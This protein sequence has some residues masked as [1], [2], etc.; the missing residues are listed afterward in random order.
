LR[1]SAAT[2]ALTKMINQIKAERGRLKTLAADS[3]LMVQGEGMEL[4]YVGIYENGILYHR[5]VVIG[6]V[7]TGYK[8]SGVWFQ[9]EPY[10]QSQLRRKFEMEIPVQ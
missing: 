4:F 9:H 1:T 8:I 2:D 5:L 7:T 3:Y 6:D 10:P